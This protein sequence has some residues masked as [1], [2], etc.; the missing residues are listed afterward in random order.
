MSAKQLAAL[1]CGGALAALGA[2]RQLSLDPPWQATAM[3][4]L[5]LAILLALLAAFVRALAWAP[6]SLWLTTLTVY[7][8]ALLVRPPLPAFLVWLYAALAL[9]ASLLCLSV[10]A[11]R[12]AEFGRGLSGL[13][14]D[15]RLRPSRVL[16]LTLIPAW[17]AAAVLAKTGVEPQAPV[18]PRSV[19]PAPPDHVDIRGKGYALAT[20]ENPYRKLE[21]DD[22]PSFAGRVAEGRQVYYRNC[23]FCHGDHLDGQGPFAPALN[24]RPAN[25]RDPGTIAMLQ[26]SF[27]FW[28][29]AKGGPGLPASGHPWSSA[30]PRWEKT[31]SEE[32]I[33]KAI[34]WLYA[35]TGQ[36][37]RTWKEAPHK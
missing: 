9:L 35:Y 36:S 25:F 33:W 13:V 10:G 20:L 32:E 16:L 29:V 18:H 37:P 30:M 5:F 24:P 2:C 28:R 26:E 22:P 4:I 21:K 15:P 31:L 34:L 11:D 23:V 14:D 7:D 3:N 6:V 12:L 17:A 19:H 1:G 8:I 27:V